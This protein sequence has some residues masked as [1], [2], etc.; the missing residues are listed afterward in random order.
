MYFGAWWFADYYGTYFKGKYYSSGKK[1]VGSY[2]KTVFE[3]S[4]IAGS[5][6]FKFYRNDSTKKT[7]TS[8]NTAA[9]MIIKDYIYQIVTGFF[10]ISNKIEFHFRISE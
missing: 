6:S 8:W 9:N 5:D 2:N 1:T 10:G 4:G 3:N 7:L